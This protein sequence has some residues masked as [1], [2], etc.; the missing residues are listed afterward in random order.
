MWDACKMRYYSA[1]KKNKILPFVIVYIE[2]ENITVSE[3]I[4]S[5]RDKYC[6]IILIGSI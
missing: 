4:W 5:Q 6:I 2:L 3:I 1:F